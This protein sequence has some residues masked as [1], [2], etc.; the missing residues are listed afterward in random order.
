M[1]SV[2]NTIQ[3]LNPTASTQRNDNIGDLVARLSHNYSKDHIEFS[4]IT[5]ILAQHI[6][7]PQSIIHQL[8]QHII[9]QFHYRV[10]NET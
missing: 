9:H 10:Q 3:R 1:P 7:D 4:I 5:I 8:S 6:Y 2:R